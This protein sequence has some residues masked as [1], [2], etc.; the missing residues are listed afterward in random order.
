MLAFDLRIKSFN[1]ATVMLSSSI[2]FSCKSFLI[3][4][5]LF[6]L[7]VPESDFFSTLI[8]FLNVD[9]RLFV[10]FCFLDTYFYY[11]MVS[12]LTAPFISSQRVFG[13]ESLFI[14]IVSLIFAF[15]ISWYSVSKSKLLFSS[16]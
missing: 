12:F 3:V 15:I 1:L 6:V 9:S 2:F 11:F 7:L 13:F 10:S 4:S 16:K 8:S 14:E 5:I